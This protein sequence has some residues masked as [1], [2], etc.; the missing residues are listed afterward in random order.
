VC[1]WGGEGGVYLHLYI[2]T[3]RL[4]FVTHDLG[5]CTYFKATRHPKP[6]LFD[7]SVFREIF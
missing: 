2:N 4:F 3:L 6:I 1:V 5:M 7:V